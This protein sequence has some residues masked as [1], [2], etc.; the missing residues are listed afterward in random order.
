MQV[1]KGS[2][3][4]NPMDCLRLTLSREGWWGLTRGVGATMIR[5]IPGNSIFFTSYEILRR[6]VPGRPEQRGHVRSFREILADATSAILCGGFAGIIM[7]C[8]VLPLDV[9]KTRLQAAF[10]GDKYD[11]RISQQLKLVCIL[12]P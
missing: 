7:W 10:P 1:A 5:E 11:L 9:S 4:H 8:F 12:Q 2:K 6:Y 3:F